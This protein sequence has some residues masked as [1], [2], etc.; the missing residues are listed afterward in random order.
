MSHQVHQFM[1]NSGLLGK[2]SLHATRGNII[3]LAV[4]GDI[5]QVTDTALVANEWI[6]RMSKYPYY[7]DIVA[8][9]SLNNSIPH[10]GDPGGAK[11]GLSMSAAVALNAAL[12]AGA[13]SLAYGSVSH[14]GAQTLAKARTT[15]LEHVNR[16][17]TGH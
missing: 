6:K 9:L 7:V 14:F 11:R 4:F 15:S 10:K 12:N 1:Y 2:A 8:M 3:G 13:Y 5:H 17:F 16:A